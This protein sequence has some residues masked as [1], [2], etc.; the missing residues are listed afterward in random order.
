MSDLESLSHLSATSAVTRTILEGAEG[1]HS[2]VEELMQELVALD[3]QLRDDA[4]EADHDHQTVL[5]KLRIAQERLTSSILQAQS[6]ATMAK[7]D[8]AERHRRHARVDSDVL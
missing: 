6:Q 5:A 7:M 2:G 1:G 8:L 3:S 4:A